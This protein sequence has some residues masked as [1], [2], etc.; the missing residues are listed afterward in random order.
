MVHRMSEF[1]PAAWLVFLLAGAVIVLAAGI[2]KGAMG[3]GMGMLAVPMLS[4][5]VPPAQA[6]GLMVVPVLWSNVV[7][8]IERGSPIYSVKRFRWL[9]VS[10]LLSVVLT[11]RLTSSL[12]ADQ[13]NVMFACAILVSVLLMATR[14]NVRIAPRHETAASV[15]A[16]ITAGV[17]GG[18]SSLTS[19]V[20]ITYLMALNLKR[21]EFIG[22]ISVIYLFGS[23]FMYSAMVWYG[24][25]GAFELLV[26]CATVL[27]ML[28]GLALGKKIRYRLSETRFRALL[29]AFLTVL[30]T[31]LLFK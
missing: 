12:S 1:Q 5:F 11:V 14:P 4:L 7:Q 18:V 8:T 22:S 13:M 3:V 25:F 21:E 31:V 6:I 16:G 20:L 2:V 9:I 19:P 30:A 15:L 27:P 17:M 29:L 26:S 10:Q 23:V 28:L 24:R